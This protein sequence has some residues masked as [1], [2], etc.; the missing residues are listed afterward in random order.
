[1]TDE[2]DNSSSEGD[3]GT[4]SSS[5]AL[6]ERRYLS[7]SKG[8]QEHVANSAVKDSGDSDR[9]VEKGGSKETSSGDDVPSA[10]S[11]SIPSSVDSSEPSSTRDGSDGG[12]SGS[13][14]E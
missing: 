8:Q 2:S 14:E 11:R 13:S 1:M 3:S 5:E 12:D 4:D 7:K 6:S 10:S 9:R